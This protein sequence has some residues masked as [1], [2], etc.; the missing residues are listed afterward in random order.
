MRTIL[1]AV[2]AS[3]HAIR[4]AQFVVELARSLRHPVTVIIACPVPAPGA[5]QLLPYQN[6]ADLE[7]QFNEAGNRI[8]APIVA[9]LKEANIA[10]GVHLGKDSPAECIARLVKEQRCDAVVVGTGG[11]SRARELIL[12]SVVS[13]VCHLVD[14]P[15]IFVK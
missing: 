15:V 7:Q 12:G 4:A 2:D 1:V 9:L 3:E 13:K 5:W 14:V 6:A 8:V 11:T 10:H